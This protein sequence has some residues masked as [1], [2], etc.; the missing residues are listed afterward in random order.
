ME[1]LILIDGNSLLN[2]AF[3]ALPP[4]INEE[5]MPTGAVFGF[6]TML[7][8]IIAEYKPDYICVAIDMP[9]P[10]FRHKL[11]PEYKAT[12]R[13]MPD[14]L[15]VQIPLLKEMLD[16]MGITA[17]GIQ[18]FEADDVIG[19]L[20]K[21]YPV[22]TYIVTGDRDCL[23][24]IDDNTI[25]LLTKK[26]ISEVAVMDRENLASAMGLAP[27]QIIDYKALAG[28]SSDN[29]PGV[30]GVGDKTALG[31]LAKY[32]TV[33]IVYKNALDIAGAVGK[34]IIENK[35]SAYLSRTLAHIEC[36]V[37]MDVKLS[38]LRF[39][40]P[41]KTAVKAIFRRHRFNTLLKRGGLFEASDD[42]DI[43]EDGLDEGGI[44]ELVEQVKEKRAVAKKPKKEPKEKAKA[45]PQ[46]EPKEIQVRIS[47]SGVKKPHSNIIEIHTAEELA[48]A[49]EP[50]TS[51]ALYIGQN[52]HIASDTATEYRVNLSVDLLGDGLSLADALA[53]LKGK[54]ADPSVTK[55]LFDAKAVMTSLAPYGITVEGYDDV[56]LMQYLVDMTVDYGTAKSLLGFYE[57]EISQAAGGLLFIKGELTQWLNKLGMQGLYRD[58]E[59][60]LIRVLFGMERRGFWV[61]TEGL[62]NL[63][64][65]YAARLESLT[66][67][68]HGA[69]GTGFNINSP[70]QLG[71]VLFGTLQI[72]YPKK[73]KGKS[74]GYSTASEILLPLAAEHPIAKNVISYRALFKLNNT[75]VEGLLTAA[76][77]KGVVRTNFRQ[78]QTSTGRLSSIEPNLQISPCAT[79]KG[80][81][82]ASFF[83]RRR[84][85]FLSPP[86]TAR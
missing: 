27:S 86:T 30:P 60:P 11:Y 31:L 68:I 54:L 59:L 69:A 75:Y 42:D 67:E 23:Q 72:P 58:I 7:F 73:Q 33:D 70:K 43:I 79:M 35:E 1:K 62:Q 20:S 39:E 19:T 48:A 83:C 38:D 29:I 2:R 24:L 13:K 28:D 78:M 51:F 15:A 71:E 10:T 44:E 49:V 57:V 5:G 66:A 55:T 61:D 32:G 82:S 16:A 52:I 37:P 47:D 14:E 53:A 25:V 9:G 36:D 8:K 21:R 74:G 46:K 12:R 18:G 3:Y 65:E 84:A 81:Y 76:G 40:Y 6:A 50:L 45:K 4:L 64:S 34:K 56:K 26:G 77:T 22:L 41:F 17:V 85:T 63:G 80:V